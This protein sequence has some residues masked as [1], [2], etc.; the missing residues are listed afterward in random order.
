MDIQNKPMVGNKWI[1]TD[2]TL[3]V[4]NPFTKDMIAEIR[5]GGPVELAL[6][7][8]AMED[9]QQSA[10]ELASWKRARILADISDRIT[11]NSE[12][13]AELITA[14]AGKPIR[15]S[16]AEVAR[17][18]VTFRQASAEVLA[19]VE[20]WLPL[21]IQSDMPARIALVKR[22]PVGP[23]L[24]I[25]P[26]NFPLNL[27]AHKLAPAIASGC[28]VLLKPASK[29]PLTALKLG[30]LLIESNLPEGMV[31]IVP[32]AASDA[33]KILAS[34]A[35]RMLTFT[36]SSE[37]GWSLKSAA[38]RKRVSLEL[39]GNAAAVILPDA[40]LDF[41]VNRC[42]TGGFAYAG[43]ICI[44][45]Q[46]IY[47]HESMYHLFIQKF[48]PLVE[49]LTVG[50][51]MLETTRVGPMIDEMSA[52][53]IEQQV[54]S[55]VNEGAELL[56][57]GRR[58]NN[59]FFPSVLANVPEDHYLNQEEVFAPLTV[60]YPFADF[61]EAMDRVNHSRFG[62][63]AGV[64]TLNWPAIWK[65]FQSVDAGGIVI[66]D[67]PTVR[68][69]NYPYGGIKDSGFGREGVRY[70]MEEMTEYKALVLPS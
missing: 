29:T 40:D 39:G 15:E 4:F 41:A 23:V 11:E 56:T 7:I 38:N 9:V 63:Q 22:F 5:Q 45:L 53:R 30:K 46:R 14:E 28:P 16:R 19:A 69:D 25:T 64:F 31:N 36:G 65:S 42:L 8:R 37:A 48:I 52:I 33:Q 24:A 61:Q 32:C 60:I 67:I 34:P 51:P 35:I 17:A 50:D 58:N 44:S 3:Q 68:V 47:V 13:L 62:L 70:A 27:V 26:F 2:R 18:A 57:G 59:L 1:D 6:A 55:A 66:N 49:A 54:Q 10:R 43:Q 21:D 20:H 12:E